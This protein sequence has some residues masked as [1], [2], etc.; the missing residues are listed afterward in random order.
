MHKMVQW[1]RNWP[2]VEQ[3]HSD[4]HRSLLPAGEP[5]NNTQ[6][7]F[8]YTLLIDVADR[9]AIRCQQKPPDDFHFPKES[10]DAFEASCEVRGTPPLT[11][12]LLSQGCQSPSN[13]YKADIILVEVSADFYDTREFVLRN[14]AS[15]WTAF[16]R[17][18]WKRASRSNA[19]SQSSCPRRSCCK[20]H[21]S[22]SCIISIPS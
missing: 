7:V 4:C 11:T 9:P 14:P 1:F 19:T 13:C 12:W 16:L 20:D 5:R 10:Y 6:N 3:C 17:V 21:Q 8:R 2:Q 18:T 22:L 15:H